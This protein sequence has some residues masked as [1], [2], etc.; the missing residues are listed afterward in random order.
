MKKKQRYL[1]AALVLLV[2]LIVMAGSRT[3]PEIEK[4][5]TWDSLET[6]A[7]F[8]R[9]CL[10]CHSYET[11]WPWYS[12]VAP[13]SWMVIHNV[14]KAR[15]EFNVSS[16]QL[17]EANEAAEEVA[18]GEMPPWDYLIL[19]PEAKLTPVEKETLMAGLQ[20]TFQGVVGSHADHDDDDD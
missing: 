16:L 7:L 15:A 6:K 4:Q 10:D 9:A 11:K 3:N 2:L 8:D 1:W 14:N 13:A 18:E 20:K 17:G 5:V 19:H 12:Y